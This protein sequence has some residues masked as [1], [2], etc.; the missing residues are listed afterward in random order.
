[1]VPL[2]PQ[3]S[4]LWHLPPSH[5]ILNMP[6]FQRQFK[7][8]V[9][10]LLCYRNVRMRNSELWQLP[11][12]MY[13]TNMT[14]GRGVTG[15]STSRMINALSGYNTG[16]RNTLLDLHE[17]N[18]EG[19]GS[20]ATLRLTSRSLTHQ[21][22]YWLLTCWWP[23]KRQ[24]DDHNVWTGQTEAWVILAGQQ[25]HSYKRALSI[26]LT[27]TVLLTTYVQ[28]NVFVPRLGTL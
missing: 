13:S 26:H 3:T 25:A 28:F 27:L 9:Y 10:R 21:R 24:T 1:M 7:Q 14:W 11:V 19:Q 2:A 5:K 23:N 20:N 4:C 22:S 6:L 15:D 16:I 8:T 18:R 17:M 12:L